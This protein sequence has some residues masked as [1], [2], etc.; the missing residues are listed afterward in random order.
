MEETAVS[1]CSGT[2]TWRENNHTLCHH[3]GKS[4]G[5]R[6]KSL[7]GRG[8]FHSKNRLLTALGTTVWETVTATMN[9]QELSLANFGPLAS[10]NKETRNMVTSMASKT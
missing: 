4:F 1:R 2:T 9:A 7:Q 8:S 6:R 10:E 5:L 3:F